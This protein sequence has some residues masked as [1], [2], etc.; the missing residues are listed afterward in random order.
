MHVLGLAR[1]AAVAL[2]AIAA[3]TAVAAPA[4]AAPRAR[5][6]TAAAAAAELAGHD[7]PVQCVS[8]PAFNAAAYEAPDQLWAYGIAGLYNAST[9]EIL[10]TNAVCSG[11]ATLPTL[12]ARPL[13]QSAALAVFTLAH[14]IGH[15]LYGPDEATADR[16]GLAHASALAYLLGLR[17]RENYWMLADWIRNYAPLHAGVE[18]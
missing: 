9:K 13:S 8:V 2:V 7:V 4:T 11:L 5:A 15:S 16:Y 3:A 1:R 14:E 10:V 17:T 6:A 12:G 18:R